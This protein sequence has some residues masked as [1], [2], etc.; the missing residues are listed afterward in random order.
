MFAP[1]GDFL[2]EFGGEGSGDGQLGRFA[3]AGGGGANGIVVGTD[4]NVYVADTW[5]HRIAVY[6]PDGVFLRAWGAFFDAADDPAASQ[7]NDS[8]FYGP[9]GLAAH[10]GRIYVTDT[11]NERVQVFTE[12]GTFVTMLGTPGDG[13]G[14]LREPVG[15]AVGP[16]G[17]IYVADS[18]NA[19]IARFSAEGDWLTPW[20]VEQWAEQ[21][22]FEPY[23]ALGPDGTL[24]ATA[25]TAGVVAVTSS[26]G[27]PGEPLGETE[28]RQPYGI[29][30]STDGGSLLVTD[31]T[32]HAV[33]TIPIPVP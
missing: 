10:D 25:S 13:D 21:Q 30:L 11:G 15:I 12:D 26:T 33:V 4:G 27:A 18:H 16:D 20:P 14:Q 6:S 31:G 5:N 8:M 1:N 3:T 7:T 9:R 29:T 28:L 17:T 24:Y 32:L 22:F 23:L 2:L 19:R